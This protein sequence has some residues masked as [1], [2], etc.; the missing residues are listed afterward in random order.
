MFHDL[1]PFLWLSI[2]N[3]TLFPILFCPFLFFIFLTL[4][5]PPVFPYLHWPSVCL[6]F[7]A[8]IIE[9]YWV[10]SAD[11]EM[12]VMDLSVL[13]R[14]CWVYAD[15][16]AVRIHRAIAEPLNT[17][18]EHIVHAQKWHSSYST[19]TCACSHTQVQLYNTLSQENLCLSTRDLT[20]GTSESNSKQTRYGE[21]S[22]FSK[23]SY[24]PAPTIDRG[25]LP[26]SPGCLMTFVSRPVL[27]CLGGPECSDQ[28]SLRKDIK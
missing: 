16:C 21:L 27:R 28:H 5:S 1:S 20:C 19:C 22:S 10:W 15:T 23:P 17:V 11:G 24:A 12:A 4:L 3:H 8:W 25:G 9:A 13:F 26:N 14:K 2:F 6:S 18:G 7:R